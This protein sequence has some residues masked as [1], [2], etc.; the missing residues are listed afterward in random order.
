MRRFWS[1]KAGVLPMSSKLVMAVAACV[2]VVGSPASAQTYP[3]RPV[4]LVIPFPAGGG[5]DIFARLIGRKLQDNMGQTFVADN[6]A[7]ASGII[8]CEMVARANPDGYTLLM[9]TTGTHST[10]PAV[11]AKLPYDSLKDFTPISLVAESPFVLLV[12]PALPVKSVKDLIAYAK[13]RPGQLTYGSA[14]IG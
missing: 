13:A 10:N 4:R 3:A 8:G 1:N 14:G 9:G 6:R 7:G 11:Y 5:A 12:H 2:A